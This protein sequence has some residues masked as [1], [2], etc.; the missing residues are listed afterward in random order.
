MRFLGF[1]VEEFGSSV[2]PVAG[3]IIVF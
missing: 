1:R 3:G 2:P